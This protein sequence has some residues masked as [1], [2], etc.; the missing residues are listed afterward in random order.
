MPGPRPT[1][2]RRRDVVAVG[3]GL[4]PGSARASAGGQGPVCPAVTKN[5]CGAPS[6]ANTARSAL[7]ERRRLHTSRE[8]NFEFRFS[9]RGI[10]LPT[11]S[12]FK[13]QEWEPGDVKVMRKRLGR[14][15]AEI[16]QEAGLSEQQY[17]KY[18]RG[19]ID[20]LLLDIKIQQAL[21]RLAAQSEAG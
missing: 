6:G 10:E 15:E 13:P 19:E 18:E 8:G 4:R 2:H 12:V 16:A 5:H 9:S 20:D 11:G 17:L 7:A 21:A 1:G 3:G 14:T